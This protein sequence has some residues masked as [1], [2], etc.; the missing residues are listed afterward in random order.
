MIYYNKSHETRAPTGGDDDGVGLHRPP[1]RAFD[2]EGPVG[3]DD[4]I[5]GVR[6]HWVGGWLCV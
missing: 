1:R 3:M 5:G 6:R 4:W 2:H